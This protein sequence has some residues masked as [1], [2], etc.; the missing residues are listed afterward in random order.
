M[1]VGW[2]EQDSKQIALRNVNMK[3]ATY[4]LLAHQVGVFTLN[5]DA[6]RA[7]KA[8]KLNGLCCGN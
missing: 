8:K 1:F 7:L 4:M 2:S 3:P 5:Q 6:S